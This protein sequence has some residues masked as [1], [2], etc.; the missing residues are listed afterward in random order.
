MWFEW[1]QHWS[2]P[3]SR[4]ERSWS[5]LSRWYKWKRE[6]RMLLPIN[7]RSICCNKD[8]RD[9]VTT[10]ITS[11]KVLKTKV[12][13]GLHSLITLDIS[14][15]KTVYM[16]L[17]YIASLCFVQF[18]CWLN[19]S[20]LAKSSSMSVHQI[21]FWDHLNQHI[22]NLN[23]VVLIFFPVIDHFVYLIVQL[24][25]PHRPLI[26]LVTQLF[27]INHYLCSEPWSK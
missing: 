21:A 25:Y 27:L 7:K 18:L 15:S 23:S 1:I 26:I 3:R 14:H 8:Y 20:K 17:I 16:E 6:R 11:I 10:P 12:S 9:V 2:W 24:A 22:P 19:P 13:V 5:D 4:Q